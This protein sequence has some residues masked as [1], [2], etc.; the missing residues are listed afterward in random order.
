MGDSVMTPEVDLFTSHVPQGRQACSRCCLLSTEGGPTPGLFLNREL[1][2]VA[3]KAIN[4]CTRC[5]GTGLEDALGET[6]EYAF[7]R[8]L[9]DRMKHY[10]GPTP[11]MKNL[12][13]SIALAHDLVLPREEILERVQQ[14]L[15]LIATERRLLDEEVHELGL[16]MHMLDTL[17]LPAKQDRDVVTK[18]GRGVFYETLVQLLGLCQCEEGAPP[19]RERL[20]ATALLERTLETLQALFPG[21]EADTPLKG[22]ASDAQIY[23]IVLAM[24]LQLTKLHERAGAETM[25]RELE[26]LCLV[27]DAWDR[28]GQPRGCL[29]ERLAQRFRRGYA[30]K[31]QSICRRRLTEEEIRPFTLTGNIP[32]EIGGVTAVLFADLYDLVRKYGTRDA[33][34][35]M[36]Q[37]TLNRPAQI[38]IIISSRQDIYR[39]I[40]MQNDA[41][42]K[43]GMHVLAIK[44]SGKPDMI[45]W[46]KRIE[47]RHLRRFIDLCDR[48]A[49][50]VGL[51]D[52][53][54]GERLS[55][56]DQQPSKMSVEACFSHP[57][58]VMPV[59]P[60]QDAEALRQGF[61]YPEQ[62]AI[63][64]DPIMGHYLCH[65]DQVDLVK[66][67]Q[68]LAET[69]LAEHGLKIEQMTLQDV[70]K[71]RGEIDRI[72]KGHVN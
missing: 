42:G 11:E 50:E 68:E 26:L 44:G 64:N 41:K 29:A 3:E 71:H 33:E 17:L 48:Q 57:G 20:Q 35:H 8:L 18:M 61:D 23:P 9:R 63:L 53:E 40:I 37:L 19:C 27:T 14:S 54:R 28:A 16:T 22:E 31:L 15:T 34:Q 58:T 24:S 2:S 39:M 13:L 46:D 5:A 47:E 6:S 59:F 67:R 55:R 7:I 56:P 10:Q 4:L 32:E 52:F 51:F 70:L 60:G 21:Q 72:M 49:A 25:A 66:Q 69:Y 65:I 38:T 12:E 62:V 30:Q 45:L 1:E 43:E 36:I